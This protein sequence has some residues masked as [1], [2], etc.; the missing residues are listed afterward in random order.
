MFTNESLIEL[1][2]KVLN[3]PSLVQSFSGVRT[4]FGKGPEIADPHSVLAQAYGYA[5]ARRQLAD[6]PLCTLLV[7]RDPRPTG[8]A[9]ASALVKGFLAAATGSPRRLEVIDLGII[10]TPLLE[11]A[12]RALGASGGVMVTASHNPVTDN[13]FKF[14]T[15][16]QAVDSPDPNEAPPGALLSAPAMGDVVDFV[17][18]I[19]NGDAGEFLTCIRKIDAKTLKKSFGNGEDH[20]HRV[21]AERAYL[22]F[23]GSEWGV[24]PHC[25]KP[26]TL[27]PTLLD[28]NGGSACGIGARVLEH[29]GVRAIE[30]NAELGYPEH[31]I[32]TDGIDPASGRH[33]LLRVSRAI[34]RHGARFGIAFDYDADRG[35]LVLPGSEED[36]IIRPQTVATLNIALALS[37]RE[38]TRAKSDRKLA[39]VVSDATS[40]SCDKVAAYFGAQVFTVETGEI[41]VVT[42]MYQ[43]RREGY[44]VPVGV[45]GANGGSIFDSATCRDGLQT[46]LCS[47]LADEQPTLARQWMRVLS[48]NG[49]HSPSRKALRLPEILSEIPCHYN[50]M[51]RFEGSA[52]SHSDVKD[53]IEHTFKT[54][55]WPTL[56]D[57][58][59]SYRFADYEG[60][61]AVESR[62]GDQTGGWRLIL[63]DGKDRAF[64]F[65]RGSRTEAG[66]W[67]IIADDPDEARFNRLL[68]G[69]ISMMEQATS[70]QIKLARR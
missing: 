9:V 27:G 67:R 29:F 70:G 64:V 48:R 58:Y 62:T 38:I 53:R 31:A 28:P 50:R 45:E 36:A 19:A 23:L 54:S 17:Q 40:G 68:E 34:Q 33:M 66:V 51:L 44:D 57:V 59:R 7:G 49:Q 55:I 30:V 4:R 2:K 5:Y 11:T 26:L 65:V 42:K 47:A 14:L 52:M 32:D 37:H 8:E 43:L 3:D 39:V 13:G 16:V 46:A 69:S 21:K 56:S 24:Q 61:S 35:N 12:V 15:G 18:K 20:M 41:N 60:T 10:T 1:L 25:L 63:D 6:L 22:D